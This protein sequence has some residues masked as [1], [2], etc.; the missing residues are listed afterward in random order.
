[1]TRR[2]RRGILEAVL[3]PV[4][5][6]CT[7]TVVDDPM[8]ILLTALLA[9]LLGLTGRLGAFQADTK[10]K[11]GPQPGESLPGPFHFLNVNGSHA[12]VPHCLVCE[13]G[14]E[15]VVLVF[16]REV[17]DKGTPL[18][19]LLK[20]LDEAVSR[21]QTAR[22]RAIAAF[23]SPEVGN[24]DTRVEL[25]RRVQGLA[26]SPD[27]DL[28]QVALS[29]G[30]EA[31]PEKYNLSKEADVTVLLYYKLKIEANFAYAKGKLTDKDVTAILA[32][33]DKMVAA[34]K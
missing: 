10:L 33:V 12:G 4:P 19:N 13:Y 30:G 6:D 31:G 34:S 22:L 2:L 32:A 21:H 14:L 27:M 1:L 7:L 25:V 24:E 8:R 18:A 26:N 20:K 29:V 16:A 11:S 28:K 3:F 17:P 15:P 9:L 23:L 5:R